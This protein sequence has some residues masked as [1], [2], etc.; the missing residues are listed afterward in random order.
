MTLPRLPT[1]MR[2]R[3]GEAPPLPIE[4]EAQLLSALERLDAAAED[5]SVAL[6]Q[7]PKHYVEAVR[8]GSLWMACSRRGAF[9]TKVQF[10]PGDTILSERH[11]RASREASFRG[12]WRF[13]FS[14]PD[15]TGIDREQ[16]ESLF[17]AYW[18]GTDWPVPILSDQ[19]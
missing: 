4:N 7:S 12:F 18:H 13:L 16:V 2:F 10:Y 1:A 14:P 3:L 6:F 11:V 8:R 15:L 9:W 19:A 5:T 17:K